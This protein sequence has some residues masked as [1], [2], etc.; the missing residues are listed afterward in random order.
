MQPW[1]S[2][3]K[4]TWRCMCG[5]AIAALGLA[6]SA[7]S[8][9]NALYT[10]GPQISTEPVPGPDNQYGY[11]VA[12]SADGTRAAIGVPFASISVGTTTY[13][14]AGKV[15]VLGYNNSGANGG[16]WSLIKELDDP[17]PESNDFFGQAVALSPDGHTA[18]IGAP[19]ATLKGT[20]GSAANA[21]K[22]YFYNDSGGSWAEI[23][24]LDDTPTGGGGPL[25]NDEF[26]Y[27]VA[28]GGASSFALVAMIGAPG[29]TVV[30]TG[31][32]NCSSTAGAIYLFDV[33]NGTPAAASPAE[34]QDPDALAATTNGADNGYRFGAAVAL[35]A[36]GGTA[37]FGTPYASVSTATAAGK[38][39]LSVFGGTTWGNLTETDDPGATAN[40]HFG[41]VLVLSGNGALALAG[42]PD[43]VSSAGTTYLYMRNG[44]ALSLASNIIEPGGQVTGDRFG[45]ALG[46][47]GDSSL[48]IIGSPGSTVTDTTSTYASTG[49]GK[50]YVY[51]VGSWSASVYTLADPDALSASA[52]GIAADFNFG[53]AVALSAVNGTTLV[54][55]P[56]TT[57]NSN[58][59][60]GTADFYFNP[61][62]LSLQLTANPSPASLN[63]QF[64]YLF[65]V[66]SKNPLI[67]NG[68]N[69]AQTTNA[70]NVVL[71]DT[72]PAAVTFSIAN[73]NAPNGATGNC[74]NRSGTVTCTLSSLAP[75]GVWQPS[76]TVTTGASPSV[77]DNQSASVSAD[78]LET[79][80]SDNSASVNVT[81]DDAPTA[82]SN[83]P[84]S[85]IPVHV[86]YSG[87]LRVAPAYSN[88]SLTY[89]LVSNPAHGS[90][91]LNPAS[92]TYT[93]NAGAGYGNVSG[94]QPDSFTFSAY[95]GYL[96]SNTA[97]VN[98]QVYAA[99]T[100][101]NA[102]LTVHVIASGKLSAT[103]PDPSQIPVFGLVVTP[104][105]GSVTLNATT[106]NYTYTSAP[107]YTGSDRFAFQVKDSYNVSNTASVNLTVYAAPQA[108]TASYSVTENQLLHAA[109]AVTE[110]DP[111]QTL[112][113]SIVQPPAHG[114]VVLNAS[115]GAFTYAPV[116]N[117]SG[118]DSFTFN[119][120]DGFNTSN[121]ATVTADV[122]SASPP[123]TPPSSSSSGGGGTDPISLLWLG[124]ICL[125]LIYSHR[126]QVLGRRDR[127]AVGGRGIR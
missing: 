39:Y 56:K 10:A 1:L 124:L 51:S 113:Y 21:G 76:I 85:A 59:V 73:D 118:S 50:A 38:A 20:S 65:T 7:G 117:Y 90:I 107:G 63:R 27:A 48:A 37:L 102:T 66:T 77:P 13:L 119:A 75:G 26:G 41:A 2:V 97:R 71:T 44:T 96:N 36:D 103:D 127:C 30:C 4:L 62:D 70:S 52:N 3:S 49:A 69:Q 14:N 35:S 18:L 116:Q 115:T 98:L 122:V 68:V 105:H 100:A 93:Y 54:G 58:V 111:T 78:Q 5:A 24:E 8:M 31:T 61:V 104:V 91:V 28:L 23:Q 89:N 109:L 84:A 45:A 46:F 106:G 82:V 86:S 72:L 22:A 121:T 67:V 125:C 32:P 94:G 12:I 110:P 42:V 112:T 55:A 60:A 17:N 74:S 40:D 92:G 83:A 87:T 16:S 57:V 25:P 88:Q 95:D 99:P 120:H 11:A 126:R 9:A 19:G 79:D 47:S 81:V 123:A 114:S 43:A 29:T 64:S 80:N 15:Y 6:F 53:A 108:S 101:A 34:F 33:A